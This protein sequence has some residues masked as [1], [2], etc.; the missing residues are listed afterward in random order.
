MKETS[1]PF[2]G[3]KVGAEFSPSAIL[4][5]RSVGGGFPPPHPFWNQE[6]GQLK[7]PVWGEE[8][9]RDKGD[10]EGL[11]MGELSGLPGYFDGEKYYN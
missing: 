2:Y 11:F 4:A 5:L 7:T 9:W 8:A 1:I 10:A 6:G 3:E